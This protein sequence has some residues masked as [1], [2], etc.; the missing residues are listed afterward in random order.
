MTKRLVRA[1]VRYGLRHA[2]VRRLVAA[3]LAA[4]R[5]SVVAAPS[6]GTTIHARTF[7]DGYGVA[8]PLDPTLRDKLKPGWRTMFDPAAA[9]ASPT[10][11]ALRAGA[12]KADKVV[13]EALRSV[14]TVAGV[15]LAGRILEIGCYDGSAA[16]QLARA[17]GIHVVAS[18]LARY[19]VVQRRGD[20]TDLDVAKQQVAL[21][22]LRERART[23]AGTP[24]GRVEFIEDDI[25]TSG[26]EPASF[27]AIVSFEV[28]E[29]VQ[30]PAAAFASMARLLKPGGIG[31][32]DYNP[33][34]SL[35]GG[36]SLCT[37][38]F[39]WGHA[40]LGREDFERYLVEIRP[41]EVGQALR[42]Y[43]ESLNR[44]THDE[45]RA[46]IVAAGLELLAVIPW[47][48]RALLPRLTPDILAEVRRTY[49]TAGVE[50][51]LAT[52]VAVI[53]RRPS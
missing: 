7:I 17:E 47:F 39:P 4:T 5:P 24:P 33:F 23:I 34:F 27:D 26:L 3:E 20:P 9:S 10:D 52:F 30:R 25:S 28:L 22:E 18:D 8:H 45:L 51:L 44:M 43:R 38:D 40:R 48:D 41:T 19:Y 11:D 2:R 1:S 32:H 21:S 35:I 16:F 15:P 14:A 31:Y 42:F 49:P 12:T 29:H 46:S 6:A 36:H 13:D 37:L 53:V 50:D